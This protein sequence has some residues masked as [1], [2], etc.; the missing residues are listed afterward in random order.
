[1]TRARFNRPRV[2]APALHL[3][4]FA[5]MVLASRKQDDWDF[6]G[7]V[8]FYTLFGLFFLDFPFSIIPMARLWDESETSLVPALIF[9]GVVGTAWWFLLG[10]SIEVLI[11]RLRRKSQTSE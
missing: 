3:I 7:P 5:V 6:R 11:R 10:V 4:V 1:M 9:W 8:A 2:I